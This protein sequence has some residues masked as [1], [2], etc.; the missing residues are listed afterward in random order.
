MLGGGTGWLLA[1]L[2][3]VKPDCTVMY[4]D[5]SKKMIEMAAGKSGD[6]AQN[7]SFI[8]GTERDIPAGCIFDAVVTHFYL[9]LFDKDSCA[10]VTRRLRGFCRPGSLW[11]ACDFIRVKP[12]H[13]M[14][15]RL[16]YAFFNVSSG[17]KTKALPDWR[18]SILESGFIEV[19]S[20]YFFGNFIC[21]ALYRLAA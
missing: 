8:H 3:S 18:K 16:M 17:L 20:E 4:I 9:D 19:R 7:V 1:E 5:S 6:A 2:L 13:G 11:L 21:T 12:W 10:Q 14:M 15:L